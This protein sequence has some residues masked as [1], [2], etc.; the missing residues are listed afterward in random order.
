MIHTF[1]RYKRI[2]NFCVCTYN[3]YR[4]IAVCV[5][6]CVVHKYIM[7]RYREYLLGFETLNDGI[8]NLESVV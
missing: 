6:L 2:C 5:C 1:I 7:N 4:H 3:T 8:V